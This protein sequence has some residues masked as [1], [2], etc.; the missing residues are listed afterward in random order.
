[1]MIFVIFMYKRDWYERLVFFCWNE[2][3]VRLMWEEN[4]FVMFIVIF[5]EVRKLIFEL[6]Y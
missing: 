1:M 6:F 2:L 5:L 3:F 4:I